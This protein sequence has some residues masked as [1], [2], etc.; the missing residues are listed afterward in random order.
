[1]REYNLDAAYT[2]R[3]IIGLPGE[4][5]V[6]DHQNAR[7]LSKVWFY[8][9]WDN[10]TNTYLVEQGVASQHDRTNYGPAFIY[11]RGN[12]AAVR[13][14]N[15]DA[16]DDWNS[17][18]W[19]SFTGYNT[20]GSL[21]M[22]ADANGYETRYT[23]SDSFSDAITRNTYAYPTQ[24][25]NPAG[26]S[27]Y[28]QYNYDM[29]LTTRTQDPKGA[30]FTNLYDAARRPER[31]TNQVNNA[32]TRWVYA[33]R[34]Y[35]A[36][37]TTVEAGAPEAYSATSFDGAWRVHAVAS[38]HPGSVGGYKAQQILRDAMGRTM[39][40]SHPTEINGSWL[41]SGDDAAGWVWSYQSYDWKGR[42]TVTTNAD[43]TTS[44]V[45]YGGCGC[46]GGETVTTTDEAG[47]KQR[48]TADVLGRAWKMET[49]NTDGSV[50]RT[51]TKTY[52]AL[53]RV[54]NITD[55][56]G[57]SGAAQVTSMAYDGHGR[58][59]KQRAPHQTAD[60]I[61]TYN[62]D[63]TLANVTDARGAVTTYSYN[64]RHLPT[65]VS[66]SAPT[67]VAVSSNAFFDYDA[68]GNRVT[69][70]DGFGTVNYQYDT[71][72]RLTS[73]TRTFSDP[74]N[75]S[76]NGQAKTLSYTYNLAGGLKSITDP[77]GS[78]V[79]Y[80]YDH[81]G[82]LTGVGGTPYG[83]ISQY[84][85]TMQYRAWDALKSLS[86]GNART[87]N[88]QYNTRL[89]VSRYEIPGLVASEY[90]Y[91]TSV[92]GSDNDGRVKFVRDLSQADS[93]FDRAYRYDHT[94]MLVEG[95]SGSEARGGV[96][97][98]GPYRETFTHDAW[99]NVYERTR[100]HWQNDYNESFVYN[101]TTGRN[102]SWTY[103]AA[104]NVTVMGVRQYQWDAAGLMSKMTDQVQTLH[105]TTQRTLRRWYDGD[106]QHL[107]ETKNAT[108]IYRLRSSVLGGRVITELDAV[109][110][111]KLT[112]VYAGGELMA[113]QEAGAVRW[114]H[115][116]PHDVSVWETSATGAYAGRTEL[117]A[118]GADVGLAP[119]PA[120]P[121]PEPVFSTYGNA[122]DLGNDVYVDGVPAPQFLSLM[123]IGMSHYN[124][125]LTG[126][127]AQQEYNFVDAWDDYFIAPD[128]NNPSDGGTTGSRN[129][130]MFV[131]ATG[132]NSLQTSVVMKNPLT[133]TQ[134]DELEK[135]LRKLLSENETCRNFIEQMLTE[136]GNT[137]RN[138]PITTS[139]ME[140]FSI[141]S[142]QLGFAFGTEYRAGAAG[143]AESGYSGVYQTGGYSQVLL[144]SGIATNYPNAQKVKDEHLYVTLGE[145]THIAGRKTYGPNYPY[146][147]SAGYGDNQLLRAG[148]KVAPGLQIK[149][150]TNIPDPNTD[151]YNYSSRLYHQLL[152]RACGRKI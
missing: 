99:G 29:G 40:S 102:Q 42:P 131:K 92:G 26:H 65:G 86:Y 96:V 27:S 8:Y 23:Y 76:I 5:R 126:G 109:G 127:V 143:T 80:G 133:A 83:G 30:V 10:S 141:V 135:A 56:Q 15:A 37:F 77:T 7:W 147:G 71:L 20:Q 52:D 6:Y 119:P 22:S 142:N 129:V 16:P 34:G 123:L 98:D 145:L 39:M 66:Y 49:L 59:W 74:A 14:W 151:V 94:G 139:M 130:G 144:S 88:L 44:S 85:S 101:Q 19:A 110:A 48:M 150:P 152:E 35:F 64:S 107:K 1:Y 33:P 91:T 125:Q 111:K 106:G 67:N 121:I 18:V 115:R 103:D 4:T 75:S 149:A 134:V 51:T 2:T 81:T 3:R 17:A 120:Q 32:Y 114:Q 53:D 104:G 70:V 54:T 97:A 87:L 108:T 62:A 136:A 41:P 38:D 116:A 55:R 46:A 63:D 47:R 79:T 13:R 45:T 100:R 61:Y 113:K 25:T 28:V 36:T 12:L 93:P 137:A 118:V 128:P 57:T 95:L 89:Q 58:L 72:S 138:P 69:M 90:R 43:G 132:N 105:G 68:A 140:L 50:Y 60:A 148:A 21:I 73:E 122:S 31:V 146:H 124:L 82:R 117:D 24:V 78:E 9:D 11:G 112:N 84:A